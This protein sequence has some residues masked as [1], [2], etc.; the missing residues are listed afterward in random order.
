MELFEL[1]DFLIEEGIATDEEIRLVTNIN[2]YN[3]KSLNDILEVRTG[4]RSIE[5][6]K[7][8]VYDE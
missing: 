8:S 5:Q 3:N 6:Y 1:W 4:Y 7:E 2:G